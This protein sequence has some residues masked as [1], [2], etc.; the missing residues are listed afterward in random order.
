M[1][2]QFE[3]E[4]NRA[5][6]IFIATVTG[7]AERLAIDSLRSAFARGRH[8]T[9]GHAVASAGNDAPAA[10]IEPHHRSAPA[11]ATSEAVLLDRLVLFIRENP[12]W[13]TGQIGRY[14]GVH[15]SKLRRPLR[16]LVADGAI[17]IEERAIGTGARKYRTYLVVEH[18]NGECA[19]PSAVPAEATA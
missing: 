17:R 16:K 12:G 13:H 15:T 2:G 9:S 14:L 19:E 3:Q 4:M 1:T 10:R 6:E 18:I 5:L 7:A 11:S 8:H